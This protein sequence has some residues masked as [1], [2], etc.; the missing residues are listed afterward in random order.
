[1]SFDHLLV[2]AYDIQ[3]MAIEMAAA[4]Q[5]RREQHRQGGPRLAPAVDQPAIRRNAELAFA[6][7]PGLFGSF[8]DT[9]NPDWFGPAVNEF[10]RALG[11]LF[12]GHDTGQVKAKKDEPQSGG[13]LTGTDFYYSNDELQDLSGSESYLEKWTG[14][15]AMAFKKTVIDPFPSIAYNQFQMVAALRAGL[16]AEREIWVHTR[17]DIDQIAHDTLAA[18]D[19]V[20]SNIFPCDRNEWEMTF[21]VVGAVITIPAAVASG[22][23]AVALAVAAGGATVAATVAGQAKPQKTVRFHGETAEAVISEMRDAIAMLATYAQQEEAKVADGMSGLLRALHGERSSFVAKR[24]DLANATPQNVTGP[25][26]MGYA[27]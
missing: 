26:H 1:V 25:L 13:P 27:H 18:L 3:R 10:N 24:P 20:G 12:L 11:R 2:H 21:S 7:I 22:G 5:T 4:A 23:A 15:A 17:H 9:P 14:K 6:D 16:E 8:V 19:R